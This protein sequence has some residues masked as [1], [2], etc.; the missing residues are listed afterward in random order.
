MIVAGCTTG[1]QLVVKCPNTRILE[2]PAQ[3][4]RFKS[5][6]GRDIT[7]I[8]FEV[9]FEG[10]RGICTIS[11]DEVEV[12]VK[13]LIVANSGPANA[14][15]K[16]KFNFFIAIVDQERNILSREE[17]EGEVSFLGNQVTAAYVDDFEMTIPLMS[18]KSADNFLIYFGF[19]LSPEEFDYN[20][21][22]KI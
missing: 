22:K 8:E 14:S 15:R 7:D 11:E 3:L 4:T 1:D 16:A 6:S 20:R 12:E 13:L 10:I 18:G 19:V 17:F 21:Q 5:G 2:E 9:V